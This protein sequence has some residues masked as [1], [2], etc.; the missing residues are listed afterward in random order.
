MRNYKFTFRLPLAHPTSQLTAA[1]RH[2]C[3]IRITRTDVVCI[4]A[5]IMH[6]LALS[7]F[8]R[9]EVSERQVT[10]HVPVMDADS[11][12]LRYAKD[13]QDL[14]QPSV[15][16]LN[17]SFPLYSSLFQ[18]YISLTLSLDGKLSYIIRKF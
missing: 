8:S 10:N 15:L 1:L 14:P 18:C 5:R 3:L 16:K 2:L 12:L 4:L 13:E 6:G 11:W 9:R 7:Q 17:F